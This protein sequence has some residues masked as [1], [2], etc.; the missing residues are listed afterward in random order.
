MSTHAELA[1]IL[2]PARHILLDFDGPVCSVFGGTTPTWAA[3]QLRAVM[4]RAGLSVPKLAEHGADPLGLFQLAAE[5]HPDTRQHLADALEEVEVGAITRAVPTPG[6]LDLLHACARTGRAVAIVSNNSANAIR[7]YIDDHDLRT[8]IAVLSAR[9]SAD[10]NLM[11]PHPFLV[12]QAMREL[13]APPAAAIMIGDSEADVRAAQTLGVRTIG[14]GNKRGKAS[15]LATA[16]ALAIVESMNDLA[17]A[18]D[19]S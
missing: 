6:A 4:D 18:I 7:R 12:D 16:G 15:V 3:T 5:L 2:R 19:L 1:A 11:K 17:A 9:T 8:L 10:P 13:G 14:Y